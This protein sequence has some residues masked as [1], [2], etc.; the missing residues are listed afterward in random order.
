[1]ERN[2]SLLRRLDGLCA[3]TASQAR[4][5]QRRLQEVEEAMAANQPGKIPSCGTAVPAA[6]SGGQCGPVGAQKAEI[7][8]LTRR[9]AEAQAEL[10]R[11]ETR[12]FAY[13]RAM[14]ALRRENAE[15]QALCEKARE[16][17]ALPPPEPTQQ[18][19]VLEKPRAAG[20]P[21]P[22]PGPGCGHGPDGRGGVHRDPAGH[23]HP[24]VGAEDKA[25]SSFGGYPLPAETAD[26]YLKSKKKRPL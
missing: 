16:G 15:L 20:D 18:P 3:E 12:L 13:E 19:P 24:R 6:A 14:V 8:L 21:F 11:Y 7:E 2:I 26:G 23:R 1:M 9:L 4:R 17:E 22:S 5:A 25:R 10:R